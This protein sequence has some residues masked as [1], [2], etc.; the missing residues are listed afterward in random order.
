MECKDVLKSID[1]YFEERLSDI[2]RH[3]I[4]KHLKVCQGCSEEFKEYENV[5]DILYNHTIVLPPVNFT[6]TVMEKIDNFEKAKDESKR[7]ITE[8]INRIGLSLVAAGLLIVSMNA[9]SVNYKLN[10]IPNYVMKGSVEISQRITNPF[11]KVTQGLNY[12]SGYWS[13]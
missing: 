12:I 10:S 1:L 11:L 4:Q 13:E 6:D 9:M 8:N 3:N 5:F 2:E 7:K